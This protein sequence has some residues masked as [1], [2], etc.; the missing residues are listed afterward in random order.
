M[1]TVDCGSTWEVLATWLLQWLAHVLHSFTLLIHLSS[2][3]ECLL[4]LSKELHN[5]QS[6]RGEMHAQCWDIERLRWRVVNRKGGKEAG[7]K[8]SGKQLLQ[9]SSHK[10]RKAGL[11]E[12]MSQP[13]LWPVKEDIAIFPQETPNLAWKNPHCWAF[14]QSPLPPS[15]MLV[16]QSGEVLVTP[17]CPTSRPHGL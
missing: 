10:E 4:Y 16:S 13:R 11:S 3:V 7:G 8:A 12:R 17:S 5:S 15:H 14:I 1:N 9:L 6:S 2:I